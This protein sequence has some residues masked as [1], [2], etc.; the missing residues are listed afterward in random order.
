MCFCM[1]VQLLCVD[2]RFASVV[3]VVGVVGVVA[4]EGCSEQPILGHCSE[5]ICA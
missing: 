4:E 2:W 3:G 1:F 5:G